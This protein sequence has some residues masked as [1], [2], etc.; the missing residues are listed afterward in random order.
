[1][2]RAVAGTAA[3]AAMSPAA[4]RVRKSFKLSLP[5]VRDDFVRVFFRG[6]TSSRRGSSPTALAA[7]RSPQ[8]E[9]GHAWRS[10][11]ASVGKPMQTQVQGA[12]PPFRLPAPTAVR[13]DSR[14]NGIQSPRSR[15]CRSLHHPSAGQLAN[16]AQQP[17]KLH[18]LGIELFTSG[19]ERL[20]AL[21]GKRVGRQAD[22]RDVARLGLALQAPCRFPAVDDRH[23]QVHQDKVRPLGSR[24]LASFFAI[25]GDQH[26]DLIGELKP[27][28]EHVS[29]VLVVFDVE[30]TEHGSPP[31]GESV[32]EY[33]RR[34][35]SSTTSTH[36]VN[37]AQNCL[38]SCR[39]RPRRTRS[40]GLDINGGNGHFLD[41][42]LRVTASTRIE[43]LPPSSWQIPAPSCWRTRT[44]GRGAYAID[45]S[46]GTARYFVAALQMERTNLPARS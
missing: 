10:G 36:H 1:M 43:A 5:F 19:G 28:L 37:R 8:R 3:A 22:D 24:N 18:R 11:E 31:L 44:A 17:I 12:L 38:A 34:H 42:D 45:H 4:V 25:L 32:C 9:V 23:L 13:S 14:S 29:V 6:E 35:L 33:A 27:H 15:L 16:F 39:L 20:L 26:F 2:S 21:A 30:N 41:A 7:S 46:D 40:L